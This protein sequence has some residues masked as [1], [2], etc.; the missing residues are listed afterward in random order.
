MTSE[1]RSIKD[2]KRLDAQ[3]RQKVYEG[4]SLQEKLELAKSRPGN[5]TKETQRIN[6]QIKK[7]KGHKH[8]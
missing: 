1:S 6:K 3:R 2:L 8:A 5:S 4:L 7:A